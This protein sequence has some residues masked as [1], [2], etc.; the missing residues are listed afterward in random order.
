VYE[1]EPY[2]SQL[3]KDTEGKPLEIEGGITLTTVVHTMVED[4]PSENKNRGRTREQSSA[5][6]TGE[7]H[8]V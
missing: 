7:S 8:A 6:S 3:D 4:S 5:Y 2:A 1:L